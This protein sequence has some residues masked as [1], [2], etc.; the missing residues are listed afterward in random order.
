M[1]LR[2]VCAC[3]ACK[4]LVDA[5]TPKFSVCCHCTVCRRATGAPYTH[6]VGF[7][8]DQVKVESGDI[9]KWESSPGCVRN[10]CKVC[11]SGVFNE[12]TVPGMEFRDIPAGTLYGNT[13]AEVPPAKNHIFYGNRVLDVKDGNK[14][15]EGFP[16]A[17]EEMPE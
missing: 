4:V 1:Q 16:Y 8:P 14:K 2:G 13:D 6:F 3:G 12:C 11:G 15:W 10:F 7:Q 5:E 17:S 9:T